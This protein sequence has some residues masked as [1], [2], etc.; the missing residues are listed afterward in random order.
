[1]QGLQANTLG[2]VI[3]SLTVFAFQDYLVNE[4]F[5]VHVAG[6]PRLGYL[7]QITSERVING[8]EELR[9]NNGQREV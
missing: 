2:N 8:V 6:I 5:H 4:L 7:H 9:M 1:M 3:T